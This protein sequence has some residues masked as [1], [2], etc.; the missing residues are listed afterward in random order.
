MAQM[1]QGGAGTEAGAGETS[2]SDEQGGTWAKAVPGRI[3][4]VARMSRT[5]AVE[6]GD[7]S[8]EPDRAMT[9][10]WRIGVVVWVSRTGARTGQ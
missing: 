1:S 8:D 9:G 10:R 4:L 7:G 5:E 6:R 2:D 3:G